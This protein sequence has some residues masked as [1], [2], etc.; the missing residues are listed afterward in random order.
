MADNL[1]PTEIKQKKRTQSRISQTTGALG[2]AGLGAFAASKAPKSQKMVRAIPR[3]KRLN[4][5]KAENASLGLSTA[6]AGVGGIGSFNFAQYTRAEADKGRRV[7]KNFYGGIEMPELPVEGINK[8]YDPEEKRMKR[9]D[10]YS[11]ATTALAGAATA[12]AAQQGRQAYRGARRIK[13][14]PNS[15][16]LKEVK[17]KG[18]K[19]THR[20]GA[21]FNALDYDVVKPTLKSGGRAALLA[22]A[23]GGSLYAGKKVR[24]KK[25]TT[26]SPYVAKS[27]FGVDHD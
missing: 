2:L 24:E 14:M 7:K 16:Q 20:Y 26:W 8:A 25:K 21:R 23:A 19:T 1:S 6:S 4:T 9:A 13:V 3:L 17:D 5:K 15:A 22:G 12:G 11:N 10:A 18:G 27:A